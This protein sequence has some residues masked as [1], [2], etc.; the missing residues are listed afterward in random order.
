MIDYVKILFNNVDVNYLCSL[1]FLDFET[2]V[3]S[4]TGELSTK[5]TANYHF[6]KIVIYE[7]EI[8]L[9]TGSIH[10]FYNSIKEVKAPNYKENGTYKGFNGNQFNINNIIEVRQHLKTLFNCKPHQ[11]IFQNIEFGINSTPVFNPQLFI[12]GLL[13]HKG[14]LF[15]FKYNEHFSQVKHQRYLL[16][17]YN[18][19]NQYQM[20]ENTLRVELKIIKTEFLKETGIRTFEDVSVQ[21]MNKAKELLLKAFDEVVYYDYTVEKKNL[22][23]RQ[24]VSLKLFSN[25]RY[26]IY[27]LNPKDRD[28]PKKKLKDFIL[29]YSQNL[30]REIRQNIIVKCVI[31]NRLSEPSKCVIIN[32]SNIGLNITH[33]ALTKHNEKRSITATV[34]SKEKDEVV[35]T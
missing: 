10:K 17:I 4:N 29:K 27:E 24:K 28:R 26:W 3:N 12:K 5:K 32:T 11:M 31:I 20:K 1:P 2:V 21:T 25:P 14:K 22:T 35:T 23:E 33:K 8:V 15:E 6:C 7:S 19:S 9:F 18:K 13:F 30:Q 34:L 16:K